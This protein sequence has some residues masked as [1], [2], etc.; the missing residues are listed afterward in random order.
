MHPSF[1]FD[2]SSLRADDHIK[3][4][5]LQSG[6]ILIKTALAANACGR[7]M[8]VIQ[9]KYPQQKNRRQILSTKAPTRVVDICVVDHVWLAMEEPPA[10]GWMGLVGTHE[11]V[12]HRGEESISHLAGA[13]TRIHSTYSPLHT[14]QSPV[15]PVKAGCIEA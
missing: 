13:M 12:L 5:V 6:K 1:Q 3:D 10:R 15:S 9:K 7:P 14:P 11:K 2:S 4:F 8:D